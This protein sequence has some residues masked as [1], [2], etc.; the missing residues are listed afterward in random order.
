MKTFISEVE[1]A[2]LILSPLILL[3]NAWVRLRDH[4]EIGALNLECLPQVIHAPVVNRT[5]LYG[6]KLSLPYI[7][8]HFRVTHH[9]HLGKLLLEFFVHAPYKLQTN[10]PFTLRVGL[11]RNEYLIS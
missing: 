5:I 11:C 6:C 1:Q 4:I 9:L 10:V 2:N 8:Y 7:N 3:N